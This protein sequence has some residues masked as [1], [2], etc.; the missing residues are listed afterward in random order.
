[1]RLFCVVLSQ[2]KEL[3]NLDLQRSVNY[4]S[5]AGK[6][7]LRGF[8]LIRP[9]CLDCFVSQCLYRVRRLD[10]PCKA[11][12]PAIPLQR[13]VKLICCSRCMNCG[14]M[15]CAPTR[16][17]YTLAAVFCGRTK[18]AP[19]VCHLQLLCTRLSNSAQRRRSF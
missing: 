19:T 14:R 8:A 15:T 11:K 6:S 12:L 4:G 18:F 10:A 3:H 13:R 7:R 2:V 17:Q 16:L 5:P 9:H 1:M